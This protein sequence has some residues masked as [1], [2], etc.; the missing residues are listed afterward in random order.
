M[1]NSK[2]NLSS[3]SD[4]RYQALFNMV[5]AGIYSCDASGVVQSFNRR[6][7]ELWGREPVPAD[8]NERFCGAYKLYHPDGSFIPRDQCPMATTLRREIAGVRDMEAIIER[9]DG[10]RINVIENICQLTGADGEISGAMSCFYDITARK[11]MEAVQQQQAEILRNNDRHKHEFLAMLAHELRNPLTPIYTALEILKQGNAAE[12]VVK[13][14]HDIMDRQ[15][16]KIIRLV[17]DLLD[18]S[19]ITRGMIMLKKDRIDLIQ[20]V[21]Q[22]LEIMQHDIKARQHELSLSLPEERMYINGDSVRLE[23]AFTSLLV[24]AIKYT[25]IGGSVA[26]IVERDGAHAHIRIADSGIGISPD[27]LPYIFDLFVLAGRPLDKK[28]GGLGIGLTLVRRIV[29]LHGGTI[30]AKSQGLDKGSEFIVCLPIVSD[31]SHW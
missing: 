8:V 26:V 15:L 27:H 11:K 20:V 21:N 25:G 24:N 14:F 29:E 4:E 5:P 7:V 19:R 12:K 18:V 16:K 28:Q 30:E 17:D 6:A 2:H 3:E 1:K 10:S 22:A 23:R 9:P 13:E 31:H